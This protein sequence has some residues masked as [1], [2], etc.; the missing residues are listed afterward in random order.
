MAAKKAAKKKTRKVAKKAPKRADKKRPEVSV[1]SRGRGRKDPK[2]RRL[3]SNLI[4]SHAPEDNKIKARI[5][6]DMML[7]EG[8]TPTDIARETGIGARSVRRYQE[9]IRKAFAGEPALDRNFY[10]MQVDARYDRIWQL[11]LRT[12]E[13]CAEFVEDVETGELRPRRP[14]AVPQLSLA[15]G[16]NE[17][18]RNANYKDMGLVRRPPEDEAPP[19][20]DV[21]INV[22]D[23]MSVEQKERIAAAMSETLIEAGELKRLKSAA[24]DE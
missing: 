4:R 17:A 2:S 11:N 21:N 20:I 6:A 14:D 16:K 13:W 15:L 7:V 22:L 24:V 23:V 9:R 5:I 10:R 18:L 3:P 12:L 8:K 19:A 1:K